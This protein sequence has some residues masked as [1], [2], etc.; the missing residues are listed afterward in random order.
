MPCVSR[1]SCLA[2]VTFSSIALL[3]SYIFTFL[4]FVFFFLFLTPVP[5]ENLSAVTQIAASHPSGVLTVSPAGKGGNTY[6]KICG[7]SL[8]KKSQISQ[9]FSQHREMMSNK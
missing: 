3:V 9:Y 1:E 5:Y 6:T 8:K 2:Q 4:F 7:W